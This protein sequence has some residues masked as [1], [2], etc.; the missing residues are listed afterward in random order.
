MQ[1][2]REKNSICRWRHDGSLCAQKQPETAALKAAIK[3]SDPVGGQPTYMHVKADVMK[4]H[5]M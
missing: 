1:E 5:N 2:E 4:S 3:E